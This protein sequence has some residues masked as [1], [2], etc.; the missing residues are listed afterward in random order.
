MLKIKT[1]KKNYNKHIRYLMFLYFFSFLIGI[2]SLSYL[3]NYKNTEYKK[4]INNQKNEYEKRLFSLEYFLHQKK[5]NETYL[6]NFKKSETYNIN[7]E[8][9]ISKFT[10]NLLGNPKG[11]KAK[12]SGYF[13]IY[14]KEK[15]VF[16]GGDGVFGYFDIDNFSEDTF[17]MKLIRSNLK[18]LIN[19]QEF[20]SKG[21]LGLKEITIDK[22]EIYIAYNKEVKKNCFNLSI[23]KA[24]INFSFFKF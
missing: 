11:A 10:N 3:N 7:D 18:N 20:F 19:Y 22:D 1:N 24:K 16:A 5:N 4:L 2:L 23:L 8:Y 13:D 17:D 15:I 14:N 9:N 6:V 12:S 21:D